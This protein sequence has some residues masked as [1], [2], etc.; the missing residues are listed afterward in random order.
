MIDE[1]QLIKPST[2]FKN[3]IHEI[4]KP[5]SQISAG[6]MPTLNQVARLKYNHLS[7]GFKLSEERKLVDIL[8][9]ERQYNPDIDPNKG[10]IFAAKNGSGTD[11]D[12]LC[13]CITGLNW[14][15]WLKKFTFLIF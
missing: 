2:I 7:K 9:L 15:I 11:D 4:N 12:P 8:I 13:I 14:L 10:F 3:L 1:N 5:E 6:K